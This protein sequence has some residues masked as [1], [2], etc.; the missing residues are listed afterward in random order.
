MLQPSCSVCHQDETT[1]QCPLCERCI[2][3]A[4]EGNWAPELDF[5]V[6]EGFFEHGL[7]TFGDI[8]SV[9]MQLG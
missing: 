6:R 1:N 2:E 3:L 9:E 5:A 4:Q 8:I 7:L